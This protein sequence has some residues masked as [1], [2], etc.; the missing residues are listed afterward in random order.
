MKSSYD[1]ALER[2][3]KKDPQSTMPLTEKQKTKIAEIDSLYRSKIAE[4]EL[5]LKPQI[6]KAGF[7]GDESTV[8]SMQK[9]LRDGVKILKDQMEEEK[10]KVRKSI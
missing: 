4:K 8:E 1:L 3:N 6:E 9:Q 10:E 5:F 2:L 7:V